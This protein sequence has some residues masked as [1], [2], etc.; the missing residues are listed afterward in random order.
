[1]QLYRGMSLSDLEQWIKEEIPIGTNFTTSREEAINFARQYH[2]LP[3]AILSIP[4][5][6]IFFGLP[7]LTSNNR[8]S[9][10]GDWYKT[11]KRIL[12]TEIDYNIE[13]F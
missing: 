9:N 4:Y 10:F 5:D 6:D 13:I 12:F 3:Y 1:M 8:N 11:Q 7:F 2:Q